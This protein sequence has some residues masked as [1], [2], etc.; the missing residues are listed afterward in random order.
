MRR[1]IGLCAAVVVLQ[2]NVVGCKRRAQPA[3]AQPLGAMTPIAPVSKDPLSALNFELAPPPAPLPRNYFD[4]NAGSAA[5]GRCAQTF[6]VPLDGRLTGVD[7]NIGKGSNDN[8]DLVLEIRSTTADGAPE[9]GATPAIATFVVP[10]ESVPRSIGS[11]DAA[12]LTGF[13]FGDAGPHVQR[14]QVMALLIRTTEGNGCIVGTVFGEQYRNGHFFSGPLRSP[15]TPHDA[16]QA[17]SAQFRIYEA[18]DD[19]GAPP[20]TGPTASTRP[21]VAHGQ[22]LRVASAAYIDTPGPTRPATTRPA[23][24]G[25]GRIIAEAISH[26]HRRRPPPPPLPQLQTAGRVFQDHDGRWLLQAFFFNASTQSRTIPSVLNDVHLTRIDDNT[27]RQAYPPG[28]QPPDR[29]YAYQSSFAQPNT[30]IIREYVLRNKD[31]PPLAPGEYWANA[32][33]LPEAAPGRSVIV[34]AR[35][36]VPAP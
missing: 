34:T 6:L 22:P 15:L 23:E 14:G 13:D 19:P 9:E 17:M 1:L 5:G 18:P 10:K 30:G 7:L 32:V 8:G 24:S 27:T 11:A 28:N 20:A 33:F 35:F 36:S 25:S 12:T 26:G 21:L 4:G 2:A 29:S 16:P 31:D 3:V